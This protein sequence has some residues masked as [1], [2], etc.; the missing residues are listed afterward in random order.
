MMDRVTKL[1]KMGGRVTQRWRTWPLIR[2]LR[3]MR[4][5]RLRPLH[6]G[7][8]GPE[9]GTQVVRYYWARFLEKHR[10]DIRG[11]CL[12]IGTTETIQQYGGEAISQADALDL[13]RHSPEVRVIADLTRADHVPSDLYDCFVV[14][15]TMTV[16]YDLEAA[17]YHAIRFLKPGGVLLINFSCVDFYLYRGLDMG[18]GSP[19]HMYWWFTPLQVE[20]LLR[21]VG[22]E[23]Q[24]YE[25][26]IYGNLFAQ[27]AYQINLPAEELTDE[28]LHHVDP[29]FP[30]LIA[31]RV[32]KPDDWQVPK[33]EYRDPLYVPQLKPAH[34]SP[35]TGHYGDEYL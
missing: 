3:M 18:T 9:Y 32:V 5:R 31:A 17:L 14:Q 24:D 28:E 4:L 8:L 22:L 13:D 35:T 6:N 10:I 1:S 12:E 29:A 33:P 34:V 16:I 2:H 11:H 20:N 27:F 26:T 21:R 15:F 7:R 19:L 25:L 30:L 23:A